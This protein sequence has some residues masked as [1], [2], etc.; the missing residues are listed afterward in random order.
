M[1]Q[2]LNY[3]LVPGKSFSFEVI[4]LTNVD[5]RPTRDPS[6]MLSLPRTPVTGIGTPPYHPF[7]ENSRCLFF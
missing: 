6:D 2:T 4:S 5:K 1:R 3:I 7:V